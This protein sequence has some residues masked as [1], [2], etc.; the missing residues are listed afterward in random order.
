MARDGSKK[1]KVEFKEMLDRK[2]SKPKRTNNPRFNSDEYAIS[3]A[4]IDRANKFVE[5]S[6]NYLDIIITD[7]LRPEKKSV[8]DE[9]YRQ[10]YRLRGLPYNPN[11]TER[12]QYFGWLTLDI[13]Y[14]RYAPMV[15]KEL[16]EITPRGRN[17]RH[18]KKLYQNLSPYGFETWECHVAVVIALMKTSKDYEDFYHRLNEQLPKYPQS[19]DDVLQYAI[20]FSQ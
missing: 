20:K 17:G 13:V 12:P 3:D 14:S 10:L 11:T 9:F 1:P 6:G 15:V 2:A 7:K 8:P 18:T 19:G 16:K 5:S 4:A